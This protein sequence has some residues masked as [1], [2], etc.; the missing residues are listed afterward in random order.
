MCVAANLPSRENLQGAHVPL[1]RSAFQL[2]IRRSV[3]VFSSGGRG[4]GGVGAGRSGPAQPDLSQTKS[5]L[6]GHRARATLRTRRPA[7]QRSWS[8]QSTTGS[9]AT[10]PRS[11][12]RCA[13]AACVRK[14]ARSTCHV[15]IFHE[16]SG[17]PRRTRWST[18]GKPPSPPVDSSTVHS[19]MGPFGARSLR[20]GGKAHA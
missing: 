20:S 7:E 8:T 6:C 9:G 13:V 3:V 12:P 14:R 4:A 5:P 18:Q 19:P 11:G 16:G 17:T 2:H 10:T 15:A 1:G